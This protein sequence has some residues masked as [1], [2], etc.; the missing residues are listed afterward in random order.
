MALL[1][2]KECGGQVSSKA[3][4]CPA[5]GAKAPKRTSLFTWVVAAAMGVTIVGGL[6]AGGGNLKTAPPRPEPTKAEQAAEASR[7]AAA[8]GLDQA[9]K[10]AAKDPDSVKYE[11]L[12][13]SADAQVVCAEFRARNGFGAYDKGIAVAVGDVVSQ[14]VRAWKKHCNR[15]MADLLY[16]VK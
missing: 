10:R 14:D 2:C 4:A 16:A 11:S 7:Y 9:L 3:A 15:P 1:K 5:C 13:V 8:Q 12:R 6:A